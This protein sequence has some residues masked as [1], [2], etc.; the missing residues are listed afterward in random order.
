[1]RRILLILMLLAPLPA[2]PQ[3]VVVSTLEHALDLSRQHNH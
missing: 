2:L 1:M 3:R